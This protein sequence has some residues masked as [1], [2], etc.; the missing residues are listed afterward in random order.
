[1]F[2][3][4]LIRF[5]FGY[6][7]I[8]V[9]GRFPERF[10]NIC[11]NHSVPVWYTHRRG[12]SIECCIFARDYRKLIGLRRGCAVSVKIKRKY[13]LPLFFHRY[14]RRKG[15]LCGAVMF[16]VILAVMPNFVW[17]IEVNSDGSIGEQQV[18][19][20]L[21]ELGLG[22]GTPRSKIDSGNM[23][24]QLAI[25]LDEVSWAAINDD[26]TTVTVEVRGAT[27][28]QENDYAYSN[29]TAKCDGWITAVYVRSGRA[30]VKVGDAVVKGQLLV[31]GTEQY[32]DGSTVFRHSDA[33][34]IAQTDH[35][36]RVSVPLKQKV[37]VDTG[38]VCNRSVVS[39]FGLKLPL[40][41]GEI[42]FDYRAQAVK[43]DLVIGSVKLPAFIATAKFY[44]VREGSITLSVEQAKERADKLLDAEKEKLLDSRELVSC[45]VKYEQ[46]EGELI[47]VAHCVCKEN[48]AKT[49]YFNVEKG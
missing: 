5:L 30:A 14:R 47:A 1:M 11:A 21:E 15:M 18:I 23:R 46:T 45:E 49:E 32:K 41:V 43:K 34:I 33:D 39:A 38:R 9:S 12:D 42:D 19:D 35:E 40:Y 29:L 48:I 20:K 6:V 17:S 4:R 24:V 16:C 10:L 37:K 22:I 27:K 8:T 3:L 2:F 36:L 26:G 28:K 13:G 31:S 7:K 25:A 44:E